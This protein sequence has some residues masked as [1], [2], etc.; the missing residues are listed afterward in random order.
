MEIFKAEIRYSKSQGVLF[1]LPLF[2]LKA[3]TTLSCANIE[4]FKWPKPCFMML[5]SICM[6]IVTQL[7]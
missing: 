2:S 1:P 3:K 6:L 5:K 4:S 7:K